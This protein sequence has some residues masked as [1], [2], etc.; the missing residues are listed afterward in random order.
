MQKEGLPK[1]LSYGDIWQPFLYRKSIFKNSTAS[2]AYEIDCMRIIDN[3][4]PL[5]DN[6]RLLIDNYAR[7]IDN[8]GSLIDKIPLII[9]NSS[10]FNRAAV[11][12]T[13]VSFYKKALFASSA[14]QM[15]RFLSACHP[16]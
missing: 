10:Y 7:V 3:L 1:K 12:S 6:I 9:D 5:I 14:P 4:E 15:D 8:I 11:I 13:A 16:A 2:T